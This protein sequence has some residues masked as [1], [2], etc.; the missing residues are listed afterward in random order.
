[1]NTSKQSWMRSL[2]VAVAAVAL[3]PAGPAAAQWKPTKPVEFVV[4]SG[5]GGGTDQFARLV[6]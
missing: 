1:M 2:S 5:A 3:L 4:P 6:Q